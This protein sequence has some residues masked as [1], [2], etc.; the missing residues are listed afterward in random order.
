VAPTRSDRPTSDLPPAVTSA[1]A[2]DGR[3]S[4]LVP[5]TP[6]LRSLFP[7]GGLRRG[8][9]VS[10][11]GAGATSLSFALLAGSQ[12]AGG[13]CAAVGTDSLGL[14]AAD[15]AGVVLSRFAVVSEAGADWPTIVAALLDAFEIILLRPPSPVS[16]A[17]H[18]RLIAR[19]RERQRVLLLLAPDGTAGLSC[20]VALIGTTGVWEGLGWGAGHLRSRQ[21]EVRAEGRRLAG[22]SRRTAVW[23]PDQHGRVA[24]VRPASAP[25]PLHRVEGVA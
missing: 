13:W 14:L 3:Q 23:I 21:I 18:Q 11:T 24:P 22:R 7:D 25:T 1:A 19:V 17:L 16:T 8:S 6:A 5:T 15:Q 2:L 20:D 10:V 12:T 9:T 4:H